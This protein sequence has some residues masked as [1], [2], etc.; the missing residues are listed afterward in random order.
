MKTGFKKLDKLINIEEPQLI[1]ISG[2]PISDLLSGDIANNICLKQEG[3]EVLEIVSHD[4][5]KLYKRMFINQAMVDSEKWNEKNKY[6]NEEL[7]QI[8]QATL[9]LLDTT[10]KL[11]TII[12]QNLILNDLRNVEK[13]VLKFATHYSK[14]EEIRHLIVLDLFP[15]NWDTYEKREENQKKIIKFIKKMKK[16]S[17]KFKTPILIIYDTMSLEKVVDRD[18]II[19]SEIYD[20]KRLEKYVDKIM[21]MNMIDSNKLKKID[22]FDVCVFDKEKFIGRCELAYNLKYRKFTDYK[23]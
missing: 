19:K 20:I 22:V 5:E 21:I 12:E 11:P 17:N 13:L 8:G 2:D 7:Q 9:N 4:K 16:I 23:E 15:L 10:T 14:R 18:F 6:T 3:N 1:L